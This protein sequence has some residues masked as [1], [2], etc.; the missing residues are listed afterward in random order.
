V[1]T[2]Q[3]DRWQFDVSCTG[4]QDGEPVLLLHGFPQGADAWAGAATE[5]ARKGYHAI[6][7]DQRGY[8]PGARPV[9][10]AAYRVRELVADALA[11]VDALVG[12]DARVHVVGHDLG[13]LVAWSLAARFPDRV[14][15][16]TAVSVPPAAA[17]RRAVLST[18]QAFA[19]WYVLAFA[20]P[21]LA[22]WVLAPRR[23]SAPLARVLRRTGQQPAAAE[24]DA[25][26]MAEPGALH[27][28]LNWYR[29]MYAARG[30]S[31]E[32]PV[33]VPAQLVWSSGEGPVT[34]AAAELAHRYVAGPFR[35]VELC[36]AS[37]WIPDEAPGALAELVIEFSTL[38]PY[39]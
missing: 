30:A 11:V 20:V 28:A 34:R 8:S 2:V 17:Y 5:L 23:R 16:L 37:H 1:P 19:S 35:Y 13:A 18:R 36:G 27:A 24:R 32:P 6:A 33:R 21:G 12:P 10:A 9:G 38:E 31:P 22:E 39:C 26:R 7:P 15:T 25:A 4:P 14:R 29:G 3:R